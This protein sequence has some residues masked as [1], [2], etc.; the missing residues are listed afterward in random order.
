MPAGRIILKSISTSRKLA[1]VKTDGARLLYTWL[2]V[3]ADINGCFSGDTAIINGAIFPRLK[4]PL[5]EIQSYLDDLAAHKLI[6]LYNYNDDVF[7]HILQFK[8][9]QPKLY[10]DRE[11]KPDI[12][13]PTHDQ[14]MQSSCVAH[15]TLPV[16][17]NINQSKDK[18][19]TYVPDGTNDSNDF[20][21]KWNEFAAKQ[22][23]CQIQSLSE[24]RKKKL[25][26]RFAEEKF[27]NNIDLI[28]KNIGKSNFLLGRG[29]SSWKIN[30]DW[31]IDNDKNYLKVIEG[32][33]NNKENYSVYQ[34][35]DSIIKEIEMGTGDPMPE[36]LKV[37]A[38]NIGKSF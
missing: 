11:R 21:D 4:K 6:V 14:L 24:G 28:F 27:K 10:P 33:Y 37:M 32:V 1:N 36:E 30:F 5:D 2:I 15:E 23:I 18:V 7:L 8:E 19:N 12:P 20:V 29:D 9:K 34:Q 17:T 3:H 38:K 13:L 25:K 16:N 31:L 22:K 35:A 26:A